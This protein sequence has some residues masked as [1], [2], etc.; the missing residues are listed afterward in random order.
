MPAINS[1]E[2]G[3][4]LKALR[5]ALGMSQVEFYTLAGIA[6]NAYSQYESGE[7]LL[8]LPQ[9]IKIREKF[10]VTLD[11]LFQGDVSGMPHALAAKILAAPL[12]QAGSP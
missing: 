5:L 4:R 7:R 10:G 11:W 3:A 12:N 1:I 8:T 2:I 9:A 6:Q